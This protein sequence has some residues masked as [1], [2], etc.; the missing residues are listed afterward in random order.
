[1]NVGVA[2]D[3]AIG[4]FSAGYQ[5]QQDSCDAAQKVAAA[6]ITTLKGA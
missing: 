1:M 5:G 6:I 2:D 4:V 3:L